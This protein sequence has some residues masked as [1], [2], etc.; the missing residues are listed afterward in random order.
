[1]VIPT[2]ILEG[3]Y[4]PVPQTILIRLRLKRKLKKKGTEYLQIN[5]T[6]GQK[7]SVKRKMIY[8]FA[9]RDLENARFEMGARRLANRN[10]N[11]FSQ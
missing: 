7:E 2:S 10:G 11:H 4:L 8:M 9:K 3:R 6:L 1:M 5:C